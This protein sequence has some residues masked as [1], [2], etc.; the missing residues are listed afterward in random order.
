MKI[1]IPGGTGQVGR[2]LSRAFLA[3][4]HEVIVL[5]RQLKSG[6]GRV[7][8]WDGE[9]LGA[10]AAEI[11]GA[12]VVVNLAGRS[13]NCRYTPRNRRLIMESRLRSTRAVGEAIA[14]AA[15]P[16]RVWLQASTATIYCH[17]YESANDET[18]GIL[19]GTEANAPDTWRFSIDV[20]RS[21]ERA[22]REAARGPTRLVLLRSAMTMSPDRGGVFDVLLGLVR[23]GLGGRHGDGRQYMSWIHEHDFIRAVYWLID[24]EELE[25]PV[26]LAAPHPLPNAEFMRALRAAWGTRFGLPATEWMLEIGTYLMRS[27]SELVLKS[28]RVV[29]RRLLESGFVFEH[30]TWPEAARDLCRRWLEMR[31]TCEPPDS[32][33][34]DR[35]PRHAGITK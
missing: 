7:V 28:R 3:D 33:R 11:D 19:G 17:R 10:W 23:W 20:A 25:G 35:V 14:R 8:E 29:P 34:W 6:L 13:V 18:T 26:N 22:A 16:P 1:V 31:R 30:S 15:R 5:S 12:D 4:G 32:F 9:T 2:I 24:H 27:E 21:W